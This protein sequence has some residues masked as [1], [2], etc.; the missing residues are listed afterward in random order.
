MMKKR[1]VI[2]VAFLLIATLIMSIGYAAVAATLT[3]G[4]NVTFRPA[5]KVIGAKDEAIKFSHDA[6][7]T[8]AN[9]AEGTVDPVTVTALVTSDDTATMNVVVNGVKDRVADYV[10]TATFTVLYDTADTTFDPVY[11]YPEANITGGDITGLHIE[12]DYSANPDGNKLVAGGEMTVT[13]T[14]TVD[15]DIAATD[16]MVRDI[17]VHLVYEDQ[18]RP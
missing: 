5:D 10:G 18:E 7:D 8:I 12:Y 11:L 6:G 2:I 13:I 15:A 3:I 17:S 14:V 1:R 9:P 4:G 16:I